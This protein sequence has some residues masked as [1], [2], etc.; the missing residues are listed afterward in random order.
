MQKTK[1]DILLDVINDKQYIDYCF[2]CCPNDYNDL[3]QYTILYL[4]EMP[5]KKITD[6]YYNS[7]LRMYIARIIYINAH[8]PRSEF[9][10]QLYGKL[11]TIEINNLHDIVDED[12]KTI[13]FLNL[14]D[15]QIEVEKQDCI[16]R[17]VYPSQVK[18]FEIYKEKKSF[19]KVSDATGIPYI[20]VRANIIAL[21]DRVVSKINI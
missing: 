16:N 19:K 11:E 10:V 2:K 17:G 14:F 8:S 12:N 7:N 6:I 18:L 5:A 13:E 21:R 1:E 4:Y 3:Y 20:T 9:K 15:N